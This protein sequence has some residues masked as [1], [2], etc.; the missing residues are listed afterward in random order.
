M[1]LLNLLL[2]SM[3]NLLKHFLKCVKP[4]EFKDVTGIVGKSR[5]CESAITESTEAGRF[6][7]V[8]SSQ[9]IETLSNPGKTSRVPVRLCNMSAPPMSNIYELQEVKLLRSLPLNNTE[10]ITAHANQR[11]V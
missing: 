4:W 1:S 3:L 11:K 5:D 9:G 10:G 8:T 7:N 6:P 2:H